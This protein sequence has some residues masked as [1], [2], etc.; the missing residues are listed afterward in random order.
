MI[1]LRTGSGVT[2][3]MYGVIETSCLIV[4]WVQLGRHFLH[5]FALFVLMTSTVIESFIQSCLRFQ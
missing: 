5:N 3:F 1:Y 2:D 4:I